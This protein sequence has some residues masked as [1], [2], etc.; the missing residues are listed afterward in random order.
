MSNQKPNPHKQ[1]LLQSISD[2]V[3]MLINQEEEV[4][5]FLRLYPHVPNQEKEEN[6]KIV[7]QQV[8]ALEKFFG[9][10]FP[11][12]KSNK[13]HISKV[14]DQ[15]KITACYFLFGKISHSFRAL[16]LLAREGFSY[17]ALE[18]IRGIHESLDL[19]HL[20][21]EEDEN[22]SILKRWFSGEI[23]DNSAARDA[24]DKFVNKDQS[25]IGEQ[26][27]LKEARAHF[28]RVLSLY[29]HIS[30]GALLESYDV[31]NRDFDFEK[32]A[33]FY[34]MKMSVL[35][36][37]QSMLES[38]IIALKH[39]YLSVRDEIMFRKLDL[40]LRESS[41]HKYQSEPDED[42]KKGILEVFE[43]FRK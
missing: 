22:S 15:N 21:L 29:T 32:N 23:V 3:R 37:V 33:G 30:Y 39:F 13:S 11:F 41:P 19:I 5:E 43:K 8:Q 26:I 36:F 34:H 7:L 35:P 12:I 4:A 10:I 18:L 16:F 17:E 42:T 2:R 25:I 20:F 24:A 27:P 38:M 1:E 31:Y 9:L 28:Y 14:T 40:I 6:R